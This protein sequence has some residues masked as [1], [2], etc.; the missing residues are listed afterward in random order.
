MLGDL[1]RQSMQQRS[2]L[3]PQAV[4][5]VAFC[6]QRVSGAVQSVL[7]PVPQQI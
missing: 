4:Q 2:P 6:R 3:P 1:L 5:L 7:V